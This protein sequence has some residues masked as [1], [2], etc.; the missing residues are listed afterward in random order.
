M[1][2]QRFNSTRQRSSYL[3]AR[4]VIPLFG[5]LLVGDASTAAG[6]NLSIVRDLAGRVG[7]IIGSALACQNI[8]RPR[9]QVIIDKFQAVIR[10]ASSTDAERDDVSRLFDR[11]VSDGRGSV[12]SGKLDCRSADRQLADLEQS[13]GVAPPPSSTLAEAIAPT[14]AQAA[15]A[16]T[17]ALPGA[18]PHGITD[19]EIRM[20][21]VIPY[22]GAVKE[23]GRMFKLGIESA[24]A[25]A[26]DTGGINGRL[27]KLY[28]ADDG[29]EPT[30]TLDAMKQLYE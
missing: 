12:T 11:H 5:A 1:S 7:P 24:F 2:I 16:P 26:N 29:Y 14:A 25:K 19:R 4:W 18:L 28:T 17:Q 21:M 8:A 30:R 10:E 23:N 15:V 20:G 3:T 9:V 6:D 13:I 22:T 27:I